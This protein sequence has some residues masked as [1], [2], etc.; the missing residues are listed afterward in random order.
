MLRQ[1]PGW[2]ESDRDSRGVRPRIGDGTTPAAGRDERRRR[3]QVVEAARAADN[4]SHATAPMPRRGTTTADSGALTSACSRAQRPGRCF[5]GIADLQHIAQRRTCRTRAVPRQPTP[6]G[7]RRSAV[8]LDSMCGRTLPTSAIVWRQNV[9]PKCRRKSTSSGERFTRSPSGDSGGRLIRSDTVRGLRPRLELPARL[10]GT[11]G[12]PR[13]SFSTAI[14]SSL[15]IQRK[16]F[17][18]SVIFSSPLACAPLRA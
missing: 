1:R 10:R 17:S 11:G 5:S 12:C 18:S 14:A 4:R 6:G 8:P 15:C 7:R 13:D 2:Y 16:V 9:Q 3:R